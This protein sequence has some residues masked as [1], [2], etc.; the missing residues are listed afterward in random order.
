MKRQ[1]GPLARALKSLEQAF[2]GVRQRVRDDRQRRRLVRAARRID[3]RAFKQPDGRLPAVEF[4]VLATD[5]SPAGMRAQERC[6]ESIRS[7]LQPAARVTVLGERP[8][9]GVRGVLESCSD[10]P[11]AVCLSTAE[12]CDD[13]TLW[14]G[15]ALA[16]VADWHALYADHADSLGSTTPLPHLK[17]DF[18]WLY[19]LARNFVE[20]F[21]VYRRDLLARAVDHL[22]T[23]PA[24]PRSAHE[25]FYALALEA[26]HD[27]DAATVLHVR[28]PLAVV[29]AASGPALP[30]VAAAALARRGVEAQASAHPLDPAVHRFT[31]GRAS[32]PHV[33]IIIPT[34]NAASLV[35]TC[36][37][38][39]RAT[40]GYDAYD[41]TVIDHDSDEPELLGYLGEESTAGR[42]SVLRYSGPF[43]YA[44]MNNAAV[45]RSTAPLVL[46]LNNDVDGFSA[47][48]LDQLVATIG[49]DR[50]IAAVGCRLVYP[51]GDIQHAGVVFTPRRH[52]F[53]G[54][55]GLPG[56]ALGYRGRLQSLQ[57]YA[58]VTAAMMLVRREAFDAVGGFDETF[59]NDYNDVD[60]CLRLR[61]A[62]HRIAY[63]PH[64]SAV[65]WESRT[66]TAKWT[67]QDVFDA[68]WADLF[69]RDPFYSPHFSA[70]E[71]VP[72]ALER[73]WRERK[74]VA[75]HDAL[76]GDARHDGSQAPPP[77][78]GPRFHPSS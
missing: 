4:L 74:L 37:A 55:A 42:M 30:G 50:A 1:R 76:V 72:D 63:T 27:L 36:I 64:V 12:L 48:W 56:D 18:S 40:A 60:L 59:P 75:L 49:L 77:T 47:G 28:H 58:A 45:R 35:T 70:R 7:Q 34:K 62:G 61:R 29:R 10:R 6:L 68:R 39:V 11:V 24:A 43:N 57:E 69:S 26:L 5:D 73:L 33:S 38:A 15:L 17:P 78:I 3:P 65:H 22:L 8:L 44:A 21:V 52:G 19:L 54:Q 14:I 25:V 23:D 20:P 31:F 67:A 2:R 13:A 9:E 53:H 32:S 66:R 71:F 16:S 46:F 51:D 41:I